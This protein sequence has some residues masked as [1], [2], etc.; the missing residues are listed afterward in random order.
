MSTPATEKSVAATTDP[1]REPFSLG[2]FVKKYAIVFILI[3]FVVLLAFLTG[4]SF[5]Q[6][7]NLPTV[8]LQ[9][10]DTPVICVLNGAAAG[11]GVEPRVAQPRQR[12]GHGQL[13]A[14]R[15]VLDLWW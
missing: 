12:L 9:E 10:M 7:R 2:D 1:D 5:L 14:P 8:V 15:D 11:Y 4:G 3:G 13:R 6:T